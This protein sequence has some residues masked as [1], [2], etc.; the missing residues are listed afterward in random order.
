M[1]AMPGNSMSPPHTAPVATYDGHRACDQRL[2]QGAKLVQG[3]VHGG[4]AKRQCR[5]SL[6]MQVELITTH[7]ADPLLRTATSKRLSSIAVSIV[8]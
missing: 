5:R 7:L 1:L 4:G 2:M 8:R 6:P 3:I